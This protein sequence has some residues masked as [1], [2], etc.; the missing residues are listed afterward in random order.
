MGA[1]WVSVLARF[2]SAP[3][4]SLGRF[5]MEHVQGRRPVVRKVRLDY[6]GSRSAACVEPRKRGLTS[7]E[8]FQ[9]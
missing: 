3:C 4:W 8:G 2:D 6:G 9:L 5:G 1:G 7:E